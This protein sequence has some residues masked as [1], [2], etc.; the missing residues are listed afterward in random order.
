[1]LKWILGLDRH[2]HQKWDARKYNFEEEEEKSKSNVQQT[3]TTLLERTPPNPP[4]RAVDPS[5]MSQCNNFHYASPLRALPLRQAEPALPCQRSKLVSDH[6]ASFAY[7]QYG[8]GV[9]ATAV[10]VHTYNNTRQNALPSERTILKEKRVDP[11]DGKRYTLYEDD[12]PPPNGEFQTLG[13]TEMMRRLQGYQAGEPPNEGIEKK[14]TNFA[15]AP[16]PDILADQALSARRHEEMDYIER[17]IVMN[18]NGEM[19]CEPE[20]IRNPVGVLGS[21]QVMLRFNPYVPETTRNDTCVTKRVG[22]VR[23]VEKA[24]KNPQANISKNKRREI[25]A[26]K[27]GVGA[28]GNIS[29]AAATDAKEAHTRRFADRTFKTPTL[30]K[31]AQ[32]PYSSSRTAQVQ[33]TEMREMKY[34]VNQERT[35]VTHYGEKPLHIPTATRK[36]KT[37]VP[38]APLMQQQMPESGGT[39][40][41]SLPVFQLNSNKET[42]IQSNR[43]TQLGPTRVH[44]SSRHAD[45]SLSKKER[46]Q[47]AMPPPQL[48]EGA[49]RVQG[50][51]VHTGRRILP[52]TA[53]GASARSVHLG[54]TG[55]NRESELARPLRT[56]AQAPLPLNRSN[57]I[58]NTHTELPVT[59]VGVRVQSKA[60]RPH[61]LR[62]TGALHLTQASASAGGIEEPV[63]EQP[64]DVTKAERS[65]VEH[66]ASVQ[67]HAMQGAPGAQAPTLSRRGQVQSGAAPGHVATSFG[68][69]NR[70]HGID[71]VHK[72]IEQKE[73]LDAGQSFV[74]DISE[75]NEKRDRPDKPVHNTLTLTQK[76]TA[77]VELEPTRD[78]IHREPTG[79]MLILEWWRPW[80]WR[81][82]LTRA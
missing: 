62:A 69:L 53:P 54:Q 2:G 81:Q 21:K 18:K 80:K 56:D 32:V 52:T 46:D 16:A 72:D 33:L 40:R 42:Q 66:Q 73:R 41:P 65:Q 19:S 58:A 17:D 68:Y 82:A 7:A 20:V 28:H 45:Y 43:F 3:S 10:D 44:H 50:T 22:N 11:Y 15:A 60:E 51:F 8:A 75:R 57:V 61:A 55:A 13:G 12:I 48:R 76:A 38:A 27:P 67:T 30:C 37:A 29:C 79:V 9:T 70:N 49:D 36:G 4:R 14:E 35:A 59:S 24:A 31:N 77:G 63:A 78:T 25:H 6:S 26:Q 64:V 74:T 34:P 71:R 39:A 23:A 47:T 5:T 1:M